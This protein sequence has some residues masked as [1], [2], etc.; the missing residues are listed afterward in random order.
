MPN[1]LPRRSGT[2]RLR[3]GDHPNVRSEELATQ[4]LETARECAAALPSGAK[5]NVD[6][7]GGFSYVH[8]R[9]MILG[10]E[11]GAAGYGLQFLVQLGNTVIFSKL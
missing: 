3:V 11:A 6:I 9:K 10:I 4:M 2:G 5:F 1:W 8:N 7:P